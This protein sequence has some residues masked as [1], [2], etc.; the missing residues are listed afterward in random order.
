MVSKRRIIKRAQ[1][2]KKQKLEDGGSKNIYLNDWFLFKVLINGDDSLHVVVQP[3]S[4]CGHSFGLVIELVAQ[5]HDKVD[6]NSN[7]ASDE[8]LILEVWHESVV[9]VK[10][11][12]DDEEEEGDVCRV[13]LEPHSERNVFSWNFLFYGGTVE[14]E[15]GKEDVDP[16][17]QAE[18]TVGTGEVAK[19]GGRGLLAVHVCQ[20]TKEGCKER[21]VVWVPISVQLEEDLR[22]HAVSG[23]AV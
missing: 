11:G 8:L 9:T 12:D 2:G 1:E 7:I 4:L 17:Q 21:S 13:R 10:E 20:K 19:N 16:G 6:S 5:D 23:Q 22:G 15:V 14:S 3:C 18:D